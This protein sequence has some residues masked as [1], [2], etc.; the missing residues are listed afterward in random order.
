MMASPYECAYRSTHPKT[1][2][3]I[4]RL[5]ASLRDNAGLFAR[6]KPSPQQERQLVETIATD[7]GRVA[8]LFDDP[9]IRAS[10][11][12]VG[13]SS[14]VGDF[15]SSAARSTASQPAG[16]R[17]LFH[18]DF[19]GQWTDAKGVSLD[20]RMT[21]NRQGTTVRGIYDFGMG[22]AELEG[23]I[24][25]DRLDYAWRWGT[26]YFGRGIMTSRAD[27][28]LSGTWGYTRRNEGGGTLDARPR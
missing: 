20:F 24:T 25:G 22:K 15:A 4:Y 17:Q 28:A 21:L 26:D 14:K 8:S 19:V 11:M 1:G 27:G 23:A 5:V 12:L 16:T 10:M 3:S 18:G 9:D 2:E 6:D 7:L 13:K